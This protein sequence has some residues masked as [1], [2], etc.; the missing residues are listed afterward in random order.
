MKQR[1]R[2]K[3]EQEI[4]VIE[5]VACNC[6]GT[7][8]KSTEWLYKTQEIKIDLSYSAS[9]SHQNI[10]EFDLCEPCILGFMKTFVHPPI[11]L[12]PLSSQLETKEVI[13][14][15]APTD[16][17]PKE[18]LYVEGYPEKEI[19]KIVQANEKEN[20]L[21]ILNSFPVISASARGVILVEQTNDVCFY[22]E[23]LKPIDWEL[24]L[25]EHGD[26]E[27]L[28]IAPLA[29]DFEGVWD[30]EQKKFTLTTE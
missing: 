3:V 15:F 19:D 14:S 13:S 7:V 10:W 16:K 28:N 20:Q 22:L 18:N 30:K 6:C 9:F 11:G 8:F 4:D 26:G 23:R 12:L 25:I 5:M 2:E 29:F 21:S 24:Y 1:K 27:Y 17:N